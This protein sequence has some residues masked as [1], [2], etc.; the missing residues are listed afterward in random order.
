MFP[1]ADSAPAVPETRVAGSLDE[2]RLHSTVYDDLHVEA[3]RVL[4]RNP[5]PRNLRDVAVA[6]ES[7]GYTT[8]AA[9]AR[10]F[11]TVFDLATAVYDLTYLYYVP[12]PEA[13]A[14]ERGT[15]RQFAVDYLAGS[16]YGVPWIMSVVVL[17]VGRVALW[18]S[19]DATPQVAAMVSLAFFLAAV[20]AGGCSQMLARKGTFYLLQQN[21]ALVRW[22]VSRFLV[23]SVAA[24]ALAIATLYALYIVPQYGLHLGEIFLEFAAAIFIF[25]LSAAP[26]YMLRRFYTLALATGLALVVTLAAAHL[27]SGS[28]PSFRHAQLLG[29]AVGSGAMVVIAASYLA[30]RSD[31]DAGGSGDTVTIIKPPELRVVLWHS[32]PYA[33]YG[34]AYFVMILVGPIITGF[35]YGHSLGVDQYLYPSTYEGSVDLALL[36]LV[37]L[38]GLVYASIERFG[39]RLR[40]LL[41][42]QTLDSWRQARA[43][44]RREW[45]LSVSVLAVVSGLVAWILPG[46]LLRLLPTT[47]TASVRTPGGLTALEVASFG[48]A[49]VPIGMLC[50]QYLFFLSKPRAPVLG[51]VAGAVTSALL[52]AVLV[53]GGDLT[54]GAWGLLAGSTV[55]A[56]ITGLASYRALSTGEES[57]YGSF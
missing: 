49:I 54:L 27:F 16:W 21:Y 30:M 33:I 14:E 9:R 39:R 20:L 7:M 53:S 36:E 37:V 50:S 40:P 38:L 15:W 25:L 45:A 26:L 46:I 8:S 17:F 55:Y 18:S 42:S 3:R 56:L 57:F 44:L 19:L 23:Y 11:D 10:G 48:F 2:L 43:A 4:D 52:T 47:L 22:T 28:S 35:A 29:L 6:L 34:M 24:A 32:A 41:E 13:V 1:E 12:Q 51:A 5:E 31:V